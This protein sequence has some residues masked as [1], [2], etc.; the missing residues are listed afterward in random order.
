MSLLMF[1]IPCSSADQ[2]FSASDLT[3]ITEQFPPYNYLEDGKLRGISVDLLEKAWE[4]MGVNLNRSVIQ[5]LPWKEGYQETLDKTNIVLFSTARLPQREQLFKW[6]GPIGPIRNV[7]LAKRDKNISITAPEDLEK[8]RIGA[9]NDDSAVQ[10]LL[11]KGVKKEDLVLETASRPIIKM[12]QNGSLDAWAYGD[13]AGIWLIQETCAN[14]SDFMVAY[15][16][17]QTD[18]YYAFNRATPDSIV[19]S[20]QQAIDR[21]KMNKDD[22]GVS[23]YEKILTKYIPAMRGTSD[24]NE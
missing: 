19:Q 21:I 5:L 23:D 12:L 4:N 11:D 14:S 17:G 18:Y 6:A 15:E 7:L 10:M 1:F 9:I 2:D 22:K 3:Y 24:I 20:F 16:F 8:Y 13:V